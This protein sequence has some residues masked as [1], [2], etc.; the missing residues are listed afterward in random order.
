MISSVSPGQRATILRRN[1][2]GK[3]YIFDIG[4]INEI[5]KSALEGDYTADI[6]VPGQPSVTFEDWSSEVFYFPLEPKKPI[7]NFEKSG[8]FLS[9]K[10]PLRIV[11]RV[12]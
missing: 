1:D 9:K 5:I 10:I 12:S 7:S 2:S 11:A 4:K 8:F 6:Q 3:Q